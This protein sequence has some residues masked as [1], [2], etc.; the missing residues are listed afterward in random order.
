MKLTV[1]R[2]RAAYGDLVAVDGVDLRVHPGQV[3]AVVGP[4]GCGKSTL[5]RAMARLHRPTSGRV[6]IGDNDIWRLRPRHAAH[7]LTLLPQAPRAPEG[8]TVTG[9]VQYGRHPHRSPLR[10]WSP[11]DERAVDEALRSTGT[12]DLADRPLDTLSG[13]Q[14]QRC[15]VAMI[16]AQQTPVLL[17]D[18]P[19]S[20][21][22]LG[23]GTEVFSLIRSLAAHG[24]S[25]VM[26]VHDLASAARYAD[27]LLTMRG[28][29]ALACGPPR[30]IVDAAMVAELYDVDADILHAPADGS[31]VIVPRPS[32]AAPPPSTTSADRT[33]A[34]EF[35]ADGVSPP[36]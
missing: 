5:L 14:R 19:T 35:A 29:R 26:V 24:H 6:L 7:R 13:G 32:G 33:D 27:M 4:N 12:V 1:Q 25:I 30:E 36:R 28:G 23:H 3:L 31:P 10:Q 2:L 17:L 22:D 9:L 16:V 21:L 11:D 15:W 18:E 8:I 34:D 20:M